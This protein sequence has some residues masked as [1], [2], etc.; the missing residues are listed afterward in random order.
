MSILQPKP[1]TLDSPHG[2]LALGLASISLGQAL[3][4][5]NGSIN[6]TALF[7]LTFALIFLSWA[8]FGRL[9]FSET[10]FR[11][12]TFPL[13]LLG[14]LLQIYQLAFDYFGSSQFLS[15]LPTL[16]QFRLGVLIAGGL[17]VASLITR[18]SSTVQ[19]TLTV[20]VLMVLWFSGAWLIEN[21]PYPFIDVFVFQQN[22]SRALINGENPYLL[23]VP[24]IYGDLSGYSTELVRDGWFTF[25]S[26]YPPLSIYLSSIGYVFWGDIRYSHLLAFLLSGALIAF[27]QSGRTSK[28]AA[29][30]FLFM[31]RSF[32]V[33]EMSWT[34]PLVV[35]LFTATIYCAL[36]HPRWLA[37]PAGLLFVSKQ[38]MLFF[39]PLILMLLPYK[40]AWS[41]W[42]KRIAQIAFVG[43]VV[44]APLAFWSF[45]S[46]VWNIVSVHLKQMLRLDALTYL[47]MYTRI[48]NV[49]PSQWIGFAVLVFCFYWTWRFFPRTPAGFSSAFAFCLLTFF[50][51]SKQAFCNYYYLVIGMICCTV[52]SF[53]PESP[54]NLLE[55][56]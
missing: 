41:V 39:V 37:I 33:L 6:V 36:Y 50:A 5:G 21:L 23:T 44:T 45:H 46:F 55:K 51:F 25:G 26:P 53:N 8:L 34:E 7:Y 18:T 32:Y 54:L 27:L 30:L 17:A 14:L 24:Y 1:H 31:P 4:N 56:S 19:N 43:L 38:Y 35:F 13:L 22:S 2:M 29:Y 3:H 49:E 47:A 48:T 12:I 15:L 16:W 10:F 52:S 9:K 42:I 20:L 11:R 40:A 28:L